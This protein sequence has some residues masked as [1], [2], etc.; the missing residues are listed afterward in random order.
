MVS[1]INMGTFHRVSNII[2]S[3]SECTELEIALKNE[4]YEFNGLNSEYLTHQTCH[5]LPGHGRKYL[6]I[7][8]NRKISMA[9]SAVHVFKNKINTTLVEVPAVFIFSLVK[10]LKDLGVILPEWFTDSTARYQCLAI[11]DNFSGYDEN[12]KAKYASQEASVEHD[13]Y[14]IILQEPKVI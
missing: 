8:R 2:L 9:I 1:T 13:G 14:K 12:G 4:S 10:R 11:A 5:F 6:I 7:C 3:L